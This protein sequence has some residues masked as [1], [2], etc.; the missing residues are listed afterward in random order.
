MN[1]FTGLLIAL[2]ATF[3]LGC[4]NGIN[5]VTTPSNSSQPNSDAIQLN[6]GAQVLLSG[7]LNLENGTVVFDDRTANPY[8]DVTGFVGSNFW[9]E[10][11][12]FDPPDEYRIDLFIHNASP[13]TVF[14]VIIVFEETY[15]KTIDNEDNFID[16][17]DPGDLDPYISFKGL[18]HMRSFP[19]GETDDQ[20][21]ELIFPPGESA[22][23]DFFILASYP[24]NVGGVYEI[25]DWNVLGH[26]TPNGSV[27]VEVS[28]F[29]HQD[30]VTEVILDTTMFSGAVTPLSPTG[31]PNVWGGTI[32]NTLGVVPDNYH[33]LLWASSPS[34]PQFTTYDMVD[35]VVFPL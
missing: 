14:D 28:V 30:D 18:G 26:L 24:G 16:I 21:L 35:V 2:I 13:F 31:P 20:R 12:R 7:T 25:T 34:N 15:G 29:D 32:D 27:D 11:D 8:L 3:S 5:Q 9:F 10:I 33:L 19:P 4:S 17:F 1:V 23:I 6:E 22:L